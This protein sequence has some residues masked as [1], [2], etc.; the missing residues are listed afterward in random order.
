MNHKKVTCSSCNKDL[1]IRVDN[2]SV[3]EPADKV[4]C[5]ACSQVPPIEP[6]KVKMNLGEALKIA[7]G[8]KRVERC[9][10]R[11]HNFVITGKHALTP[12]EEAHR[13]R[14]YGS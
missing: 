7:A 1:M 4:L 6:Q 5:K 12:R 2:G 8:R 11:D 14:I 3:H 9:G 10:H 13:K